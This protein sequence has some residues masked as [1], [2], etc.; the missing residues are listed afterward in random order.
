MFGD[1][2]G[3]IF[4]HPPSSVRLVRE[5]DVGSECP[6]VCNFKGYTYIGHNS[7]IIDQIDKQGNITSGF[8]SEGYSSIVSLRAHEDQ[9]YVLV[10]GSPYTIYVHDMSGKQ[11][12][13]WKHSDKSGGWG[14]NKL[15][16]VNNQLVVADTA[17]QQIQLYNTTTGDICKTIPCPQITANNWLAMGEGG[18]NSVVISDHISSKVFKLNLTTGAILWTHTNIQNPQGVTLLGPHHVAVSARVN[19]TKVWILNLS[20]GGCIDGINVTTH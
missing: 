10:H 9:L 15:A 2:I 12:R 18:A 13:S 7:G 11:L 19:G 5:V 17:N 16:L 3:G 20:T 6:S 1:E 8:I 4:K 14:G